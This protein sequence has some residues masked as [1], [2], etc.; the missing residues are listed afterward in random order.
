MWKLCV[1]AFAV[2][3]S[4]P[5][6][7]FSQSRA[8]LQ[9]VW[10][11]VEATLPGPNPRVQSRKM[12]GT[13]GLL[14]I[15]ERHFALVDAG[16]DK[17]RPPLPEGGAAKASA[18]ELRATWGPFTANAGTYEWTSENETTNRFIASKNP[19]DMGS[20]N[21]TSVKFPDA[22]TLIFQPVRNPAGPT[23]NA[24]IFKLTRVK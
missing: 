6:I 18:D 4:A 2:V 12:P 11:F 15:T 19:A 9:G 10:Q 17:P 21:V 16:G 23:P 13:G 8:Q 1:L 22:N 14:I 5:T 7:T 24:P 3:I 20:W